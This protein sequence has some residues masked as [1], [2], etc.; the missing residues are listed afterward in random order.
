MAETLHFRPADPYQWAQ[1]AM[2]QMVGPDLFGRH[3]AIKEVACN[4]IT[5][6]GT[7]KLRAILPDEYRERIMPL[8]E[9]QRERNRIR[10]VFGG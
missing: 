4:P 10:T 3:L 6:I 7:V 2:D 1:Q 5:E 8:V 9:Q